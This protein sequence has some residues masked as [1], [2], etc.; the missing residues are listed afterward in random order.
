MN[1]GLEKFRLSWLGPRYWPVWALWAALRLVAQL[2]FALRLRL[3]RNLGR[4]MYRLAGMRRRIAAVN[5]ELCFPELS[6]DRRQ[7]LLQEHFEALGIAAVEMPSAWWSAHGNLGPLAMVTGREHLD[8]ALA[9]GRGV[10]LASSHMLSMEVCIRLLSR[11]YYLGGVYRPNNNPLVD[12]M[13]RSG[14][15]GHNGVIFE[16]SELRGL[17]RLLRANKPVWYPVD[18][19][20][21]TRHTVF[22][23]FFGVPASTLCTIRRLAQMT[24]A[25]VVPFYFHRLAGTSGYEVVILPELDGFA[26][27]TELEGAT[28][29]NGLLEEQILRSPEQYLWVH[30][31]FKTR[32]PDETVNPAAKYPVRRKKRR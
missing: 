2:S 14:R 3:G 16:R 19:D 17:V 4:L 8:R 6:E 22:A 13:I 23:P 24:G 7:S 15:S 27:T 1:D 26:E 5:L 32:P 30:R 10:I 31:R 12:R 20:H 21:G 29:L 25:A 18:Q 9:K 11:L 28:R